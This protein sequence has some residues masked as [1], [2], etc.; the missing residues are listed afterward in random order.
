MIQILV[1]AD[2][3][4]AARLRA[5]L[6][7]V[8]FDEVEMVVAGSPAAVAGATWPIG[9]VIHEVTGWQ[10][11]DLALAAA[12]RPGT[13]PLVVVSGDGD[14]SMLAATHGGPVLVVS[15]RPSSRLRA[16]GTVV[17][18]VVDGPDAVRHW[19][20]AVLDSTME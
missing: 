6:R 18:P 3:V 15:D 20:D 17:D 1:D 5:F 14:F 12:Y 7:A 16:A 8:P 11:A 19:F 13:Q 10:Q 9:A 4:T 2:N